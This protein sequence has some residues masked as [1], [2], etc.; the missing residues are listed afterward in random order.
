MSRVRKVHKRVIVHAQDL[1]WFGT[2][3]AVIPLVVII[4]AL[5]IRVAGWVLGGWGVE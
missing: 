2:G 5:L 3:L 1:A 4:A